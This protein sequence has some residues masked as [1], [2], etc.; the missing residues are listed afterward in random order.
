MMVTD[1]DDG[2]YG[3]V[4]IN[5]DVCGMVTETVNDKYCVDM[6]CQLLCCYCDKNTMTKAKHLI[7]LRVSEG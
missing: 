4:E 6:V 1:D 3:N 2:G 5:G 7:G